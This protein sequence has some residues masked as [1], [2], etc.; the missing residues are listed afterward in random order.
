MTYLK[1]AWSS[2]LCVRLKIYAF[3]DFV[4][5]CLK[6]SRIWV[7]GLHHFKN[8]FYLIFVELELAFLIQGEFFQWMLG[9]WDIFAF[10]VQFQHSRLI[11]EKHYQK[12]SGC[13]K[14]LSRIDRSWRNSQILRCQQL[15]G[16]DWALRLQLRLMTYCFCQHRCQKRWSTICKSLLFLF[17]FFSKRP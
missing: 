9:I 6:R 4:A 10:S 3:L 15:D 17:E 13:C 11:L 16:W 1:Y 5:A 2:P 7:S 12:T 14:D 8:F